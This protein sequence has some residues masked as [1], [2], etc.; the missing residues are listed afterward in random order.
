MDTS[1]NRWYDSS[2]G[3]VPQIIVLT[4]ID[5]FFLALTE[6]FAFMG[7]MLRRLQGSW[8]KYAQISINA[9][10]EPPAPWWPLRRRRNFVKQPT[11][12]HARGIDDMTHTHDPRKQQ[13]DHFTSNITQCCDHADLSTPSFIQFTHALYVHR[14]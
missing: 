14:V 12:A 2:A 1:A 10:H 9:C 11:C 4:V 7:M 5:V 8:L 6:F 3:L 13:S